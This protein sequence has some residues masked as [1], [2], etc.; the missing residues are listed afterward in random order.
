MSLPAT[1]RIDIG[2]F[3]T[4]IERSAEIGVGRPGGLSRLALGDADREVRDIFVE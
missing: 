3:W 2:R 1:T 4:T